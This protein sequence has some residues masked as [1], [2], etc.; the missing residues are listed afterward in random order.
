MVTTGIER[1][2]LEERE[3]SQEEF[4]KMERHLNEA[5]REHSKIAVALQQTKRDAVRERERLVQA[6]ELEREHLEAELDACKGKL[7]SI[8]AERN[9]LAVCT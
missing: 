3:K 8:T 6:L 9:L 5:R 2:V 1:A 4:A 7:L